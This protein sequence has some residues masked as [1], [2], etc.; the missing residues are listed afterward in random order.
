M[1]ESEILMTAK[2]VSKEFDMNL[3]Y[4]YSLINRK[5]IVSS[6][7]KSGQLVVDRASVIN[8]FNTSMRRPGSGKRVVKYSRKVQATPEVRVMKTKKDNSSWVNF[9][10]I[11]LATILGAILGSLLVTTIIK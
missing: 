9:V 2:E 8:Y 7:L 11:V 10:S 5:K 4:V 3:N 1:K 6:Y